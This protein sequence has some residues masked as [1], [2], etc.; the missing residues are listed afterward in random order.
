MLAPRKK[1]WSSPELVLD[2][3]L[4]ML[5]IEETDVVYDIGC[6]DGRYAKYIT[7]Y[8]KKYV[9]VD[10]RD[11]SLSFAEKLLKKDQAEVAQERQD[12]SRRSDE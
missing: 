8:V 12:R 4:E 10:I 7:K 3:A 2:K 1:L 5:K 6:G 9:G 11:E